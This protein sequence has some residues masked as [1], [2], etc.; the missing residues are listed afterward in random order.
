MAGRARGAPR[1]YIRKLFAKV[2]RENGFL[3]GYAPA[4]FTIRINNGLIDMQAREQS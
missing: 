3:S 1:H 2:K 4:I